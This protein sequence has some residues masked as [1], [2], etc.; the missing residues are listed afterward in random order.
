MLLILVLTLTIFRALDV[1][2]TQRK[3]KVAKGKTIHN[4]TIHS[5]SLV[6]EIFSTL[7]L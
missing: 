4:L 1:I 5:L 3:A 6:R 2:L 7:N